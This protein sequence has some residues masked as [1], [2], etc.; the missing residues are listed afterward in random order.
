M[1]SSTKP[2][3]A[4][5]ARNALPLL[6]ACTSHGGPA[7]AY[8]DN[9]GREEVLLSNW[10]PPTGQK[11]TIAAVP[12]VLPAVESLLDTA[13][14][15]IYL[16]QGGLVDASGSTL[17]SIKFDS[18]GRPTRARAIESTLTDQA[19]DNLQ[20]AVATAL[21]SQPPGDDWG[22]RVRIDL[23]PAVLYRVGRGEVCAPAPIEVLGDRATLEPAHLD[24]RVIDKR[25]QVIRFN[26]LVGADGTV[27]DA[28]L[29]GSMENSA[30]ADDMQRFL[31]SERWKPGLDDRIPVTMSAVRAP[32]LTTETRI[33]RVP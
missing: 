10:K 6:A 24:D 19:R 28:K 31:M 14:M 1:S 22:V 3:R 25:V 9:R 20:L 33:I 23:G 2:I 29:I 26:V 27:L 17:F 8:L 16:A 15:P 7:V 4:L 11:C 32:R 30:L 18:S 5:L 12:L 21:Q 13:T